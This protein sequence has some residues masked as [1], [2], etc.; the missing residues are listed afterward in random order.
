[1][2]FCKDCKHKKGGFDE[3]LMKCKKLTRLN[4]VT[5]VEEMSHCGAIRI[6]GV[7]CTSFENKKIESVPSIARVKFII[8]V[9]ALLLAIFSFFVPVK[10]PKQFYIKWGLLAPVFLVSTV[11]GL[12][13]IKEKR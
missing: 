1:M 6:T 11:F 4:P 2:N 10:T 13:L 12:D 3:S 5:G 9:V 8:W 7:P